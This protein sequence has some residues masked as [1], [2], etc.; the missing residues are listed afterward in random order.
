MRESIIALPYRQMWKELIKE[1]Q[2]GRT[3][4]EIPE[5]QYS[6]GVENTKFKEFEEEFSFPIPRDL[7]ALYRETN[8]LFLSFQEEFSF[9]IFPKFDELVRTNRIFRGRDYSCYMPFEHL[10]LFCALPNGD[11]FAFAKNSDGTIR[12][13][14]YLWEHETDSRLFVFYSLSQLIE[15]F[16]SVED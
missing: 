7:K 3:D 14:I 10:L 9:Q 13:E 16:S 15:K 1:S 5:W 12:D 8:G 4:T 2:F 11:W 6:P